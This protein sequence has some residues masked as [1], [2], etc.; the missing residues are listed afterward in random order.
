MQPGRVKG[1]EF[2]GLFAQHKEKVRKLGGD[3]EKIKRWLV[4]VF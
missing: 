3:S 2:G 1:V 4:E